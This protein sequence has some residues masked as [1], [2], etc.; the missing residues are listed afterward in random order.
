MPEIY[1]TLALCKEKFSYF[2]LLTKEKERNF[3]NVYSSV[4]L[5]KLKDKEYFGNNL[6]NP[7]KA[8]IAIL[9]HS[10]IFESFTY[11][12]QLC[13]KMSHLKRSERQKQQLL[14]TMQPMLNLHQPREPLHLPETCRGN[15]SPQPPRSRARGLERWTTQLVSWVP[16]QI[17]TWAWLQRIPASHRRKTTF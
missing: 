7:Q 2:C 15:S 6:L 12:E 9:R 13:T 14:V 17:H 4:R 8:V 11:G 1:K 3:W 5:T 10:Q 16:E